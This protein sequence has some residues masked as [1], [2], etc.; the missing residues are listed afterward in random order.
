[1]NQEKDFEVLISLVRELI[2]LTKNKRLREALSERGDPATRL[3]KELPGAVALAWE[4]EHPGRRPPASQED[5]SEKELAS[6]RRKV[7]RRLEKQADEGESKI[8]R[9][10]R[11]EPA[12]ADE[13]DEVQAART[14]REIVKNAA[15]TP[16]EIEFHRLSSQGVEDDEIAEILGVE[17]DSVTKTKYRM[18]K[19]LRE[20]AAQSGF[21]EKVKKFL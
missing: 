6:L 19:K 13:D 10:A 5:V 11:R 12:Y 9:A 18:V 4:E 15:L 1:M 7:V 20:A 3:A 2:S 17:R 8:L 21:S 14:L 16:R